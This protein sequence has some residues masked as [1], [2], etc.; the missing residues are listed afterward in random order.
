MATATA[1]GQCSKCIEKNKTYI[2]KECSKTF[3]FNHLNDHWEIFN[4]QFNKIEDDCSSFQQTLI[5][6]K[7]NPKNRPLVEQIDKWE[8]DS[9]KKIKQTADECRKRLINYTNTFIIEIENK[10]NDLTGQFKQIRKENKCNEIDLNQ[11]KDKL[12]KLT[13]ELDK[14]PNVSI[15]QESASFINKI[16]VIISPH[17]G[18]KNHILLI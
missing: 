14:P 10:L 15:K 16:S 4:E 18:N 8:E 2:C 1:K 3:C 17:K 13:E 5:D 9:I 12:I 6:R 11:L 7:D